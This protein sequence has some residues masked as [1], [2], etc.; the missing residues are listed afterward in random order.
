MK[1]ILKST[2]YNSSGNC[3]QLQTV[4]FSSHESCYKDNGFCTNVLLS[5]ISLSCLAYEIFHFNDFWNDQGIQEVR[6]Q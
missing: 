4:A 6:K 3:S 2:V 1:V 5:N